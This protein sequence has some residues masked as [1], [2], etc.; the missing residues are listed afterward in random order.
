[1]ASRT[2]KR[3]QFLIDIAK[4]ILFADGVGISLICFDFDRSP[5]EQERYVRTGRSWTRESRHLQ[6][7]AMD[8]AVVED[9]TGVVNFSNDMTTDYEKYEKLG[10]FWEHMGPDYVWGAGTLPSGKRRDVYH[11]ELR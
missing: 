11:F 2:I 8:F 9:E 1:M 7:L 4:L 5:A 6:W 3:A 10:R